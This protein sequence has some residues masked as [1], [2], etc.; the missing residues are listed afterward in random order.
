MRVNA[1]G[2]QADEAKPPRASKRVSDAG[3]IVGKVLL[4]RWSLAKWVPE[5]STN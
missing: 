4:S 3:K 2:Q 1:V 5:I